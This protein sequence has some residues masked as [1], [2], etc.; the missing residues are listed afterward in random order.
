MAATSVTIFYDCGADVDVT[1]LCVCVC[2]GG[3]VLPHL[4]IEEI[5]VAFSSN[6]MECVGISRSYSRFLYL[7][8]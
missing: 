5:F 2:A 8:K 6:D 3:K 1:V 4:R 7:F